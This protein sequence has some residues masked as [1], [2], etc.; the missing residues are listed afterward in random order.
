[1]RP[2]I[3]L[4]LVLT[5][6][7]CV[8]RP[9]VSEDS[10]GVVGNWR[11]YSEAITLDTGGTD[12]LKGV[13]TRELEIRSDGTWNYGDSSGTWTVEQIGES[14]WKRWGVEPYNPTRKIV[15]DGW[16]GVSGDGPIEES[17]GQIDFIWVIYRSGPPVT[18]APA[19]VQIK[20]G[21][22]NS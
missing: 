13:P 22:T 19:Q 1:M 14:D 4:L 3:A 6:F 12:Y 17:S 5:F 7:G 16:A 8:S 10:M 20:F 15:L 18:S 11:I 2:I 21:H 9:E